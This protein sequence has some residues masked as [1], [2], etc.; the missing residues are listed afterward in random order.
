M[1]T[2]SELALEYWNKSPMERM[3]STLQNYVYDYMN[4]Q[5]EHLR[6]QVI[7]DAA[8]IARLKSGLEELRK[9]LESKIENNLQYGA[10]EYS[11]YKKL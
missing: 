10:E 4:N 7:A 1:K 6:T 5:N 9:F 2:A 11:Q 8:E 3:H